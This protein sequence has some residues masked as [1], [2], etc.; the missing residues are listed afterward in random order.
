LVCDFVLENPQSC[1]VHFSAFPP[2]Q[3]SASAHISA[4]AL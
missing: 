4:G 3:P 1:L 2:L